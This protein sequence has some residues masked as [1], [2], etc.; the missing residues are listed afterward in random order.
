MFIDYE[1][2]CHEFEF[3]GSDSVNAV[4]ERISRAEGMDPS[5]QILEYKDQVQPLMAILGL[6]RLSASVSHQV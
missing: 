5:Q 2:R 6:T 3:I 1:G 4:K